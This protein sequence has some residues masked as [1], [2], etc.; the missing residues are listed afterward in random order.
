VLSD[1]ATDRALTGLPVLIVNS[2]AELNASMLLA[3]H[4]LIS[5]RR[6]ELERLTRNYWIETLF[7]AACTKTN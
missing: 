5:A 1:W 6:F 7:R 4:R 2:W 3:A